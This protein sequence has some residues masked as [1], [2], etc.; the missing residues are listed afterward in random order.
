MCRVLRLVQDDKG[1][2]E[3][4]APHEGQGRDLYDP[5]FKEGLQLLVR[6]HVLQ[7]IVKRLH[8]GIELLLEVSRQKAQVLPRLDRRTR[9]DDAPDLLVLQGAHRECHGRI[10]LSRTGRP[11][12]ED[13][14]VLPDLLHHL[15][16]VDRKGL[17]QPSGNPVHEHLIRI[18]S[19]GLSVCA[20]EHPFDAVVIQ[21][22]V[23]VEIVD[24]LLKTCLEVV[25]QGRLS[26][27]P[28]LVSPGHD[29]HLGKVLFDLVH[30]PVVRTVK[31]VHGDVLKFDYP[32]VQ[33]RIFSV[34]IK[35]RGLL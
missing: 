25:Q 6:D 11:H 26:E 16:L 2:V 8:V 20:G 28:D 31:V 14:V 29:L 33:S 12:G 13:H 21:F 1:A 24:Q 32:F 19:M 27:D 9:Q 15:A 3:G 22:V 4:P 34:K 30:V 7:R 35:L 17:D 5:F 10:G 23:S 18:A